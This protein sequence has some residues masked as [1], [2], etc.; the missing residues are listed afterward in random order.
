MIN[1]RPK[2]AIPQSGRRDGGFTLIEVM[3]AAAILAVGLLGVGGLQLV[4]VRNSQAAYLRTQ[5][6][7]VA[8]DMVDRMRANLTATRNGDYDVALDDVVALPVC[9]GPLADCSTDEIADFDVAMWQQVQLSVLNQGR[10]SIVTLAAAGSTLATV[11]VEWIDPYAA[12]DGDGAA[13]PQRLTVTA[14]L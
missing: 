8:Y 9:I 13:A 5:A 4:G 11:V 6:S 12:V 1:V 7:L 14:D 3:V 2:P 10:G